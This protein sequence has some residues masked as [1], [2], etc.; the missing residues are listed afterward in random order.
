M[1]LFAVYGTLRK[2]Q[3][4]YKFF[5]GAHPEE[6]LPIKYTERLSGFSLYSLGAYPAAVQDSDGSIIVE[7]IEVMDHATAEEIAMMER[8]AGYTIETITTS[9]GD[10]ADI[11]FWGK[12][13]LVELDEGME[14]HRF[15]K[16]ENGD[17]VAF[18]KDLNRAKPRS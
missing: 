18:T 17:W 14:D 8:G 13:K 9:K 16:I 4:N 5:G 11:F 6:K 2:G 1:K 7:I 15:E 10:K 3:Y 12:H